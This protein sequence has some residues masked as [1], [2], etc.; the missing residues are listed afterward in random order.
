MLDKKYK[1]T[2]VILY[3][4]TI[5]MG[6]SMS[7]LAQYKGN[8]AHLWHT[9]LSGVLNVIAAT[10]LGGII[11]TLIT[12]PISD[13]LGRKFSAVIGHLI[14]SIYYFGLICSPNV[15][16]A[17]V[18]AIIGGGFGN[19]F[20]NAGCMP[21]LIEIFPKNASVAN[22]MTKFMISIGQFLLPLFIL[23]SSFIGIGY[24]G[25]FIGAGIV[26]LILTVILLI[27]P[28][29][30]PGEDLKKDTK[31]NNSQKSGHVTIGAVALVLIG[32]TSTAVFFLWLNTYQELA[33]QYGISQPSILQSIYA[34]AAAISVLVNSLLVKKGIKESTILIIYPLI[35]AFGLMLPIVCHQGW[36]L[37]IVSLIIGFFA[38]GGLFQLASALLAKMYPRLKATAMAFAGFMSML[39]N[40]SILTFAS[41]IV[42]NLGKYSQQGILVMNIFVCMIGV[43]LGIIVKKQEKKI[44]V[45]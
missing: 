18:I 25:I 39:A 38:A 27:L 10:G 43:L 31:V 29:P 42:Q 22:L 2:A 6:I 20:I 28:F 1:T 41:I 16:V 40:I 23:L 35:S 19:S 3:F 7:I 34:I 33:V 5:M 17:Y 45:N 24:K 21:T 32:Y 9:N 44:K 8:F 13:K 12:G 37:Y 15:A 14:Q 36:I 11:S 30:I 4:G 26:Y